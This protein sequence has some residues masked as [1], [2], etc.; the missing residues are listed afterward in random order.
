MKSLLTGLEIKSIIRRN[1]ILKMNDFEDEL[2]S[3]KQ[4]P[5]KL[6]FHNLLSPNSDVEFKISM[7][8]DLTLNNICVI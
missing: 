1:R 4:Y 2:N 6:P 3:K 8:S 5:H 7:K